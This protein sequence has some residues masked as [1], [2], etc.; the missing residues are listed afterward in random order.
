M[1][2]ATVSLI[3]V[4][5]YN[6]LLHM[7]YPWLAK[8]SSELRKFNFGYLSSAHYIYVSKDVRIRGYFSMSKESAS[9]TL[10]ETPVQAIRLTASASTLDY[11]ETLV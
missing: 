8:I 6:A 5:S 3:K 7:L 11:P 4:T 9:K 10:W 1:K 2:R